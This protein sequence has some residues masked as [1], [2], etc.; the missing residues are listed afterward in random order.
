MQLAAGC[1]K[2]KLECLR[3]EPRTTAAH[4]KLGSLLAKVI[5]P[6]H[7]LEAKLE[8][9]VLKMPYPTHQREMMILKMLS[10]KPH[11][12]AEWKK[13]EAPKHVAELKTHFHDTLLFVLF[14]L[15]FTEQSRCHPS[16]EALQPLCCCSSSCCTFASATFFV[17]YFWIRWLLQEHEIQTLEVFSCHITAIILFL[18]LCLYILRMLQSTEPT[19]GFSPCLRTVWH[20]LSTI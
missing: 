14:H 4:Q 7:T 3:A 2:A 8:R 18:T 1:G 15:S 19:R 16:R 9:V 6:S 17:L 13:A 20:T 10:N 5:N 11:E 12:F